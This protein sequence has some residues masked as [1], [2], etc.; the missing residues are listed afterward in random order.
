MEVEEG[1]EG[2]R[3]LEVSKSRR[4]F[5]EYRDFASCQGSRKKFLAKVWKGLSM[6]KVRQRE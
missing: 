1:K 3:F 6:V 2:S 4:V 5:C